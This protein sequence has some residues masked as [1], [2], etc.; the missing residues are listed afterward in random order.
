[1]ARK[2]RRGSAGTWRRTKFF[3]VS[4]LILWAGIGGWYLFQPEARKADVAR[5]V[6]N[7]FD[8]NKQ[9]TAFDVAWDLWQLYGAE[10][11]VAVVATGDRAHSYAG[12]PR[13][14]RPVRVLVNTGYVVGYSDALGNPLWAAYRVGDVELKPAPPRP[15]EFRADPRTTARVESDDYARSGYD[16]GH[17]AP[18][19]AIATRYGRAAQEE[20]FLMSNITPQQHAL[21]AGPWQKLE[22]RIATN[23][24]GRFGEVWVVVGPIFG[25]KPKKLS[26]RVSVPE[27]FFM[28]VIDEREGGVR[29]QAFVLPQ[30]APATGE[31][32]AY[33]TS[34]DEIERRTGLDFLGELPDEA[35]AKL[36]AT[37]AERM[38]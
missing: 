20:T 32:G 12:V 34:I 9:I 1:M 18:N 4:N 8:S 5:L 27:A 21:N 14:E 2:S 11:R 23:Y 31:P 33:L 26:R 38:W 15:D 10:D 25:E 19:Y 36:E 7:A 24:A 35:E 22:Q 17:M 13:T 16:R 28:I 3:I 6:W 30:E 37:K 29:A